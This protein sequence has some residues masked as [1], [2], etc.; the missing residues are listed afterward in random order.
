MDQFQFNKRATLVFLIVA[1]GLVVY[2]GIIKPYMEHKFAHIEQLMEDRN[3]QLDQ[4][5]E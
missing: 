1:F 5:P 4:I 3:E 2:T